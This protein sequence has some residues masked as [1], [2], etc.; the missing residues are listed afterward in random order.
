MRAYTPV[1]A[2]ARMMTEH[3]HSLNLAALN[4]RASATINSGPPSMIIQAA[5]GAMKRSPPVIEKAKNETPRNAA[6]SVLM[7][8]PPGR[9]TANTSQRSGGCPRTQDHGRPG[10]LQ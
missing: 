10:I 5:F 7:V 3:A 6:N 1:S 4:A 9:S 8:V 2:D